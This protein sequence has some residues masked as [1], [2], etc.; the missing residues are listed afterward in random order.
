MSLLSAV[1]LSKSFGPNDIFRGVS[2]SVPIGARIAIVGLNGIGKTTL[3]RILL[4]IEEP[5]SGRIQK[6]RS[7]TL[8]Y[9][10]QEALISDKCSL[11]DECLKAF[12]K[13]VALE[14]E[15][16]R[17][18]A[19]MADIDRS[20]AALERY[21][22]LQPEFERRGGYTYETRIRQTLSG[23]GFEPTDYFRPLTQ[24]SGGQRT[25]AA[26][27]R[28]LLS[29]PDLL[30]LDE[31]TNHLD[32]QAVEW[33]E[34]YLSQWSGATLIVS[35]DRYFLDRVVD[36]I[37]EMRAD[38]LETYRGN[39]S[40]Y[41]LQRQERWDLRQQIFKTEKARLEKELD[42]I[43][44]NIS[45]QNVQQA[46]GKLRR[47]SREIQ[48]IERLGFEA[49]QNQSWLEISSQI[50]ISGHPIGVDEIEQRIRSLRGPS[51]RPPNLHIHLKTNQ[52][53]GDLVLRTSSLSVGYPNEGK[54]L[55][56]APDLLLKR[57]DCAAVIGPNGAGKTT[58]LKTILGKMPPLEGEVIL[59][60]SLNVGYFAQAH[61]D[62]HPDRTLIQEIE[63]V[64]PHMQIASI[65]D[66]LARFLF[67]GDE[68]FNKVATLS[69]GERGR[70]A[71][72]KLSLTQANLLLLD[73][74]TNHL[75]IPSQEI[76]Q[77]VLT[78]YQGTILLVSHDRY[79]ID[80]LGSQIWEIIPGELMLRTFEGSYTKY[81]ESQLKEIEAA[82]VSLTKEAPLRNGRAQ[83]VNSS[84]KKRLQ[85]I[86]DVEIR[87]SSLE[88]ELAR[89]AQKLENPPTEISK[90][91][92]IG[93]AYAK[94]QDELEQ[95]M[96][97]WEAL[98]GHKSEAAQ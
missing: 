45:G 81:K 74:P 38:G 66:Y 39:Y 5:T 88:K 26:L 10:P 21:A 31:P 1:D 82:K 72:A 62:L 85:S 49:V 79:L 70:L 80:A 37:W 43:K 4:G 23:L 35:H 75:D 61:E 59:G 76:L 53:S 12:T 58:F 60:A 47:L 71:L 16:A 22:K 42:Y 20:E 96:K 2:L 68:V 44:R 34:G 8:G 51:N 25:R 93:T 65:R 15:L 67:Q 84:E 63:A 54:P 92:K 13:L 87:I 86:I 33:L 41:L 97:D 27:A 91:Q 52:R 57:G 24:L 18:E 6:A 90:I 3:L 94:Y 30:V 98:H 11:W 56:Y 48:A 36:H 17:L 28:L 29:E 19:E 40:A 77:G 83:P 64:A 46:K 78:D 89:L 55:F 50:E 7:L 14:A 9:L 73:E 32:I 69:G 95:L